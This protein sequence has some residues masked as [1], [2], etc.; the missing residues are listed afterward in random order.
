MVNE[1][2]DKR[3]RFNFNKNSIGDSLQWNRKFKDSY[4]QINTRANALIEAYKLL[5][6]ICSYKVDGKNKFLNLSEVF[7]AWS[8]DSEHWT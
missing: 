2:I 5:L 1:K 3:R 7:G 8:S 6:E 4:H